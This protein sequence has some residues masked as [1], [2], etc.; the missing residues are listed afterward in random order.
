MKKL[1]SFLL[2]SLGL[3]PVAAQPAFDRVLQD[4][5][6]LQRERPVVLWGTAKPGDAVTVT[7]HGKHQ[8]T[9]A[10]DDGTWEVRFPAAKAN[11]SGSSITASDSEGSATLNDVLVGEL[12]LA[13]GQS[14][15]AWMVKQTSPQSRSIDWS[16]CPQLRL[17]RADCLLKPR[18]GSY[19]LEEYDKAVEQGGYG[20]EWRVCSEA[21]VQDFS[22]VAAC[23]AQRIATTQGVPVGIICNAVGGTPMESWMPQDIIDRDPRFAALRGDA[24]T[25]SP[26]Y[27]RWATID[28]PRHI[29]P[30]VNAGRSPLHHPYRPG[31][32][33]ESSVRPLLR[34]PVRGV[35]WYQGE[36]NADDS[37]IAAHRDMITTLVQSWRDA[38]G[39]KEMPFLMVQ[40]PRFGNTKA[41]P[42]WPEFREAQRQAAQTL[43]NVGL[44][45]TIDLGSTNGN[46][47]PP[48][49]EPVAFRLADLARE[50]VYGE[51]NLPQYP[52][53]TGWR[54]E[55][56]RIRITFDRKL[57]TTDGKA[58]RGFVIGKR[59]DATSLVAAEASLRG[60][61]VTLTV[62]DALKGER[63][64]IW[65]YINST[66]AAPNLVAEKGGLPAFPVW[67]EAK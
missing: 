53:A 54:A 41:F 26:D 57:K 24:W 60:N 9:T 17:L 1:L 21:A 2:P 8:Q 19:T 58:P 16:A 61:T 7:W 52:R 64:L 13:S 40:L 30:A 11:A 12:W 48:E 39:Q 38:F 67:T 5:M 6:V 43:R 23:F 31:W 3:L 35:I 14:N 29:R 15:M 45:C 51:Q 63:P 62:P 44:A 33:F 20:W 37:D 46:I 49:K 18:K 27:F 22:A 32:L 65:R 50:M 56:G 25:V 66:A 36:A 28:G 55:R 10:A 4:H 42:Y 59:G 47:H 34:L